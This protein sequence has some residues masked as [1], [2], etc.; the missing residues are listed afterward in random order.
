MN[1]L[2]DLDE[3]IRQKFAAAHRHERKGQ[4]GAPPQTAE[5]TKAQRRFGEIADRLLR[6]VIT[7]RV[8]KLAGY[9]DNAELLKPDDIDHR[10]TCQC[11]L[12]ATSHFPASAG[13]KLTL[14]HDESAE[15]LLVLYDLQVGPDYVPV[16]GRVQL[17]FPIGQVDEGQLVRWIDDEIV[18]FVEAYLCFENPGVAHCL[19]TD[20]VC[21]MV[22]NKHHVGAE[23]E[24]E[25]R[26]YYF[27]ADNCRKK[28][29]RD[30][31]SYVTAAAA[32]PAP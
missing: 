7:P 10:Y 6:D 18:D 9:F 13:L 26:T 31:E 5:V 1:T 28:F 16:S 2:Q 3:R 4:G 32:T 20:P 14:D 11:R 22:L 25:G 30:P 21:G 17:V 23:S 24:Y 15:H 27:C 29:D 19:V 8:E 12:R